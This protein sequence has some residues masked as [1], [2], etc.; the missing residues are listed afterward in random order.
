MPR[1]QELIRTLRRRATLFSPAYIIPLP[2]NQRIP[3]AHITKR[4]LSLTVLLVEKYAVFVSI[5]LKP[6]SD[7]KSRS[8]TLDAR[9]ATS[10][11]HM[12][13]LMSQDTPTSPDSNT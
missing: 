4:A 6:G 12:G 9:I 10:P 11:L 7:S 5:A 8:L 13:S 2:F 1:S 3:V